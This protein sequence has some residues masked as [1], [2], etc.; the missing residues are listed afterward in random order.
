MCDD[1]RTTRGDA[2][3]PHVRHAKTTCGDAR[4]T[5]CATTRE[6]RAIQHAIARGHNIRNI[7][8]IFK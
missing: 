1:T 2:H 3:D 6:R 7:R 8:E 4:K 5:L